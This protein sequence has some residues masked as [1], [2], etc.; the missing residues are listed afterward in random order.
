M[1]FALTRP[2]RGADLAALDL[3][4]RIFCPE[5]LIFKPA[6]LSKQSRPS[7]FDVAFFFSSFQDDSRLCPVET[8]KEYEARTSQ[9]RTDKVDNRL[10]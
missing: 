1:L 9:F 3:N 7:H 10:F 4:N 5:V 8:L 2:C 6:Q